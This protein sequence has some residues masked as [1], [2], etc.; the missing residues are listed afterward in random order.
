MLS[1]SVICLW[2]MFAL[3]ISRIFPRTSESTAVLVIFLFL[4][5]SCCPTSPAAPLTWNFPTDYQ[6]CPYRTWRGF[7]IEVDFLSASSLYQSYTLRWNKSCI[8]CSG[9]WFLR[10]C[11]SRTTTI[12]NLC[13]S[14]QE[15]S[16]SA[17]MFAYVHVVRK[18]IASYT[19]SRFLEA[20][21]LLSIMIF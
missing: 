6:K 7:N 13:K 1:L 21:S 12:L 17:D 8:E 16:T 19:S 10:V 18:W 5:V 15:L 11:F 14:R 3:C 20:S 9:A 4:E 2:L